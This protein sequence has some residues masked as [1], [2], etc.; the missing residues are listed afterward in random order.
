M[1]HQIQTYFNS[2]KVRLKLN[3]TSEEEGLKVFQF[4]K[5]TIK[6]DILREGETPYAQFQFHKGT[7]KTCWRHKLEYYSSEISIP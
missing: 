5:G 7:I 2:I 4:H 6:T 1:A 3:W